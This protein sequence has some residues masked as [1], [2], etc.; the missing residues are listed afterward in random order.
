MTA[1]LAQIAIEEFTETVPRGRSDTAEAGRCG[2]LTARAFRGR[3]PQGCLRENAHE[4]PHAPQER[5][6][7][8]LDGAAHRRSTRHS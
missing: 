1:W 7:E 2:A 5:S 4:G 6:A 8:R 3:Y